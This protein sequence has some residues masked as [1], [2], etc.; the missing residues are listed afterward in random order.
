MRLLTLVAIGAII[1]I[2]GAAALALYYY[3]RPTILRVAVTRDS[4][5]QQVLAA[6]AHE[7]AQ[8]RE[9]LRLKP[10]LVDSLSE[11]S[12]AF[13]DERVDLAIVRSD[14]SMPVNGQTVLIMRHAAALLVAPTGADLSSVDDLRGRKVGMLEADEAGRPG[15]HALLDALLGQY[16]LS[17]ASVRRVPLT[18]AELPDA[19]ERREVD[20]VLSIEA[21]GSANL[22]GAVAAV[23]QAGHG[24]PVFV[25]IADV[26]AITQRSPNYESIE[27]VRGAFG[28]AQ[29]KPS[30][31]FQTLGVSVRLIAQH[32]LSNDVVS[33]L[34][35]LMLNAKPSLAA[36]NPI[37]NFIEAP[38]TDKGAALPVHP[39]TLAYLGDEEQGFFDKY[40]DLIYIGA[41]VAS[42]VGT[43]IA[44]LA[45]RFNRKENTDLERILQ[46]LLE[47]IAS[48][49]AALRLETLD[50]FEKEADELLARALA[51][52][53]NHALSSS[54]L[55]ATG[56][57]LSQARQAIAERRIQIGYA[58]APFAPRVVGE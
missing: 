50:D 4:D 42:L 5:D 41:M 12:H 58:R 33:E 43:A 2:A 39:G 22:T 28:G 7:F 15:D 49:R 11:A 10:V 48:A 57:A 46:R 30:E 14:I 16:D 56:L 9:S 24:S 26:K 20:V 35:E 38:S 32:N 18:L 51:H 45:A 6:A 36:H 3:E 21:P 53:W 8:R 47:I 31:S 44:T 19:I 54:R 1:T 23:T 17:P 13:E 29:P 40:S 55:A 25:P 37:A 27:I 34:T 52:D